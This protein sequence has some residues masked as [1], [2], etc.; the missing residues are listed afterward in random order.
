MNPSRFHQNLG[1]LPCDVRMDENGDLPSRNG[2][3]KELKDLEHPS[4]YHEFRLAAQSD[5]R[6]YTAIMIHGASSPHSLAERLPGC[7]HDESAT[8]TLTS[9]IA[10]S[11]EKL[12]FFA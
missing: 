9:A 3:L 4:H 10:Q 7:G 2:H 5:S 8:M 11:F 12:R 1:S 6:T